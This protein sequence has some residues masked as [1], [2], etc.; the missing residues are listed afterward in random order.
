MQIDFNQEEYIE[1]MRIFEQLRELSNRIM[2][3]ARL[4]ERLHN[5]ENISFN[6][7]GD[8]ETLQHIA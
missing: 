4:Y 5:G 6:K 2:K 7:Y 8:I 3:Y 1:Q